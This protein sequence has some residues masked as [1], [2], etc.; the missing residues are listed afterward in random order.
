MLLM[1]KRKKSEVSYVEQQQACRGNSLCT[2]SQELDSHMLDKSMAL[3]GA[4]SHVHV[5]L[6]T[7]PGFT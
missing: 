6:L 7:E 3:D 2:G 5:L 4:V 1:L